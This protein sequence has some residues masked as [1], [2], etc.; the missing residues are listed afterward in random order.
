MIQQGRGS[1]CI[2]DRCKKAITNME[3]VGI[4]SQ[5]Q[6]MQNDSRISS[7]SRFKQIKL[8]ELCYDCYDE[9]VKSLYENGF[10]DKNQKSE[11]MIKKN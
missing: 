6:Y 5:F 3:Y 10:I 1:L 4:K 7:N 9:F 11:I 8:F 2:C